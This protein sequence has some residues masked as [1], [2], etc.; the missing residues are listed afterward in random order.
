MDWWMWVISIIVAMGLLAYI[1]WFT[2]PIITVW[3]FR[4]KAIKYGMNKATKL[5]KKIKEDDD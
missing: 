4:R 1:L 2:I 5:W 3:Y